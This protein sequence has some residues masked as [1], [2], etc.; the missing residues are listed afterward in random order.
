MH[1][2]KV[3]RPKSNLS[4]QDGVSLYSPTEATVQLLVNINTVE[5]YIEQSFIIHFPLWS[6]ISEVS[7]ANHG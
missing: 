5:H 1:S 3:L 7:V 4:E 2:L 6:R